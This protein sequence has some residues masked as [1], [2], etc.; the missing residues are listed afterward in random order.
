MNAELQKTAELQDILKKGYTLDADG[1][2]VDLS[3]DERKGYEDQL[4]SARSSMV[5]FAGAL[6][7]AMNLDD[8]GTDGTVIHA[9]F[10]S[11]PEPER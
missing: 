1:N 11:F 4:L 9:A 10:P 8:S 2:R 3:D 7:D 6:A 5:S